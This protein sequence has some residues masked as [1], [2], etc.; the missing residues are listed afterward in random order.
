MT[1]NP[2][3]T[4]LTE[5]TAVQQYGVVTFLPSQF[6]C[7]ESEFTEA[8]QTVQAWN[9]LEL[10]SGKMLGLTER[11]LRTGDPKENP[12]DPFDSEGFIDEW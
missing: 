2:M 7:S 11:Y 1:D 3:P 6:S 8:Y 12:A 10:G 5:V 4:D 9:L